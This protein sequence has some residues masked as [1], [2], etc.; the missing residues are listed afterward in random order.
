MLQYFKSWHEKHGD[1]NIRLSKW[2]QP[3][4][5]AVGRMREL[6][7]EQ[8]MT[9]KLKSVCLASLSSAMPHR[10]HATSAVVQSEGFCMHH[11]FMLSW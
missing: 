6:Y 8:P 7:F 3:L 2:V 9:G 11:A 4:G 1:L 5:S 10:C